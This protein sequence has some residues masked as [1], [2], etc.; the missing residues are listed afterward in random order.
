MRDEKS[1]LH[2]PREAVKQQRIGMPVQRVKCFTRDEAAA[3]A[4]KR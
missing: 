4:V 2:T 3:E 1:E